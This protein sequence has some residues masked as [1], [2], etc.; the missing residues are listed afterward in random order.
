MKEALRR[1]FSA[2]RDALGAGERHLLSQA[3]LQRLEVLPAYHDSKATGF[4]ASF[5]SEVETLDLLAR[6]LGRGRRVALPVTQREKGL[7]RF[8]WV[9][10]LSSLRAGA[11]GILEPQALAENEVKSGELDLVLVPGLAF[12]LEGRRLGYGA[13]YY[14]RTLAGLACLK[15]GLAFDFQITA[16]LP[17]ESHD[18]ALDLVVTENRTIR[19]PHS[20]LSTT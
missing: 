9:S 15:I 20:A 19:P 18:V 12:D 11:Y 13:G 4:Y 8:Y 5:R 3:L 17:G 6:A 16:S 10:D 1:E 14:D 7:L 2:R